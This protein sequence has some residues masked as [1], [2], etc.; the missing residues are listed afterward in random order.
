[1]KLR[2]TITRAM[3]LFGLV[4]AIG[5]GAVVFTGIFALSEVK[6][7]GPLYNKL[8]LGNDLIA[9]I[10]PPPEYVIESY[11]E[12]TLALNNPAELANRRERLKQLK[13]EYDERHEFWVKS[14]LEPGSRPSSLWIRIARCSVS[15]TPSSRRSCRL[16]PRQTPPPRP[17]RIRK[18]RPPIWRTAP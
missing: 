2:L 12:A 10:L 13:K 14:D 15:G 1:M 6:V 8:K 16:W 9:D 4:T 3:V 5:L 18:S 7:G 11:L 17:R